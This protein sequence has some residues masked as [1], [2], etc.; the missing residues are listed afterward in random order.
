MESLR[1]YS[2]LVGADNV[3]VRPCVRIAVLMEWLIL[4]EQ[5]NAYGFASFLGRGMSVLPVAPTPPRWPSWA[6]LA[7]DS[8]WSRRT[9]RSARADRLNPQ[10]NLCL[11]QCANSSFQVF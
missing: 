11:L 2:S 5:L 4:V 9:D 6:A 10:T 8:R 1:E 7:L 3:R